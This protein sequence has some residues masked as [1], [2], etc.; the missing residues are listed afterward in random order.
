MR[1]IPD[2]YIYINERKHLGICIN[3]DGNMVGL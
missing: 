3:I 1:N 2:I